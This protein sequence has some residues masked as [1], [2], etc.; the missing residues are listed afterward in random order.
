MKRLY[1]LVELEYKGKKYAFIDDHSE[2]TWEGHNIKN[3]FMWTDGNYSCDCNK[4]LFIKNCCFGESDFKE[5]NCGDEIK[6]LNL[7][8]IGDWK[9]DS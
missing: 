6:L 8:F 1:V 9:E 7:T 3:D 4:S 2:F 5:M